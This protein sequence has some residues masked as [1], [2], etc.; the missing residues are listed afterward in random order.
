MKTISTIALLLSS[1]LCFS[2]TVNFNG[3]S[4]IGNNNVQINSN[5]PKL[6]EGD[7][8]RMMDFINKLKIDS[9]F[10][11][12]KYFD[13]TYA[14]G[15]NGMQVLLDIAKYLKSKGY[16]DRG[17]GGFNTAWFNG[18]PEGVLIDLNKKDSVILITVGQLNTP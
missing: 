16:I 5:Q 14:S 18:M 1:T 6:L 10:H 2:Q 7:K 8:I 9:N 3:P 12:I 11:A 13:M 4:Q 17:N 15:S